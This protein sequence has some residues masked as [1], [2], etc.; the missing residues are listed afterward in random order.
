MKGPSDLNDILSGL[1][2]KKINIA[3]KDSNSVVMLMNPERKKV[4]NDQKN[5][6][7]NP[8]ERNTISLILINLSNY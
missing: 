8:T 7:E 3:Q 4:L 2:T 5:L 6:K 1:K